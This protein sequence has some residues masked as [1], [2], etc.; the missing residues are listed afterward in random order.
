MTAHPSPA[1]RTVAVITGGSS[2]IGLA[3]ATRLTDRGGTVVL[4]GRSR[5]RLETAAGLLHARGRGRVATAT[6]DVADAAALAGICDRTADEHGRIDLMV[7]NAG[8]PVTGS[9]QELGIDHWNR[10]IETNLKGVVHGVAACY[11]LM[12]RQ[13]HGH[14]VNM[15]SLAGLIHPPLLAPYAAAKAAVVSLTL[16]LRAEAA[17]HGVRATVACPG[18]VDTPFL[19][20]TNPGLPATGFSDNSREEIRR[21]LTPLSDADTIARRI[22][23]AVD[24]NRAV[25]TGSAVSRAAWCLTR[26]APPAAAVLREAR[27]RRYRGHPAPLHR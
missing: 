25:V 16:A 23:R 4:V 3:L 13:G 8:V 2:G 7:N 15:S 14:I 12:V 18:F 27:A 22:L 21:F 11:P 5:E 19:D 10:S 24:R 9:F 20:R 6:A 1:D 17:P 26:Y